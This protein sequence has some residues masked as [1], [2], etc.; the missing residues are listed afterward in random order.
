MK[1]KGMPVQPGTLIQF[2]VVK[3]SGKVRDKV[4]LPEE[5]KQEDYDA[6][7]YI[8]NQIIPGLE[9]IFSVLG[10]DISEMALSEKQKSLEGFG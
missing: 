1:Q 7:Y 9:R 4:R 5:I 2:V 6:D 3:G 8:Q 10:I